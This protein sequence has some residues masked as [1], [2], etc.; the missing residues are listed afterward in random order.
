[1]EAVAHDPAFAKKVEIPQKVGK[2]F[3]HADAV[4]KLYPSKKKK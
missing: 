2:E 3:S 4:E 1:M